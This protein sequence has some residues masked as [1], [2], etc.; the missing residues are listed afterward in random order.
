L[1][2]FDDQVRLEIPTAPIIDKVKAK[3][4]IAS[5]QAGGMTNMSAGYLR[6]L[7][8]ARRAADGAGGT[9]LLISDG[10]ANEGIADPDT[11]NGVAA[12]AAAV[13]V[14]TST[15]GFGLG[16]DETLLRAIAA[17][18]NGSELFGEDA[19]QAMTAIS[20][21]LDGLLQQTAQAASV[22][23]R[24]A[25]TCR[26]LKVVNEM[27]VVESPEGVH[28]ELGAFYSGEVRRLVITFDVPGIGALG[29]AEIASL[30]FSW[31]AL[32]SLVQHSVN[33]PVH[34]NVLPGDQ[35]AGRIPDPVV[36]TE[37][38]FLQGQRAKRA[39]AQRM[40]QGDTGGA[41]AQMQV[42]RSM[43]AGA[44]DAAP[45][46]MM[47]DLAEDLLVLD[48]LRNEAKSGDLSRAAKRLSADTSLKSR[49]RGRAS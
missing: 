3:Q 34:V 9:V 12:K 48:E 8:E 47:K 7:Q 24:M 5:I 45:A 29:L 2:T 13:G 37:L 40:S 20:R 41:L 49:R 1:V 35:A 36:R 46:A 17:G 39:A 38:A 19:D 31:V 15:L 28:V 11:L 32:P 18:G 21:E 30:E 4:R 14:A 22:L 6:G 43:I 27:S 33:L 25:T 16:Y 44:M 26:R 42:A 23:I 10:H